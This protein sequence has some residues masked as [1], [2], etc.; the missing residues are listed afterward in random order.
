MASTNDAT[1]ALNNHNRYI[2]LDDLGSGQFGFVQ[3]CKDRTTN[4]QVAV[5]L[6]HRGSRITDYVDSEVKN[7]RYDYLPKCNHHTARPSSAP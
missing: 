4:G 5:K 1:N 6:I 3:L 2:R 7:F